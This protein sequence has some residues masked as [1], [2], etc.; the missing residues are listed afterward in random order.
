MTGSRGPGLIT[1]APDRA[2]R[3][4][5]DVDPDR[6]HALTAGTQYGRLFEH[7]L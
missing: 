1:L 4:S 6:R 5:P 2:M 7:D 3:P